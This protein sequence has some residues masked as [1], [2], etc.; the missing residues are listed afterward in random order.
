[1]RA[2]II[3]ISF[4]LL[5]T[6]CS[7]PTCREDILV[8]EEEVTV[9]VQRLE[10]V[11]FS[12]ES[13]QDVAKFLEDYPTFT[14]LFLDGDQY[15]EDSVLAEKVYG[16][17]NNAAVDTLYQEATVEYASFTS[18]Q[19]EMEMIFARLKSLYPSLHSPTVQTAVTG[20]YNDLYISDSLIIIGIDFFIGEE[21]TYRPKEIPGY[22]LQRYDREHLTAI[23][24]KFMA[25]S[26][27][28]TGSG[29][30]LLSEMIDFGK[31]YYLTSRLLPCTPDSILLGYTTEDM[32]LINENES[33][34][35]ANFVQNE[36]LYETSHIVKQKFLGERPNVHEIN[37][38]CPG[39]IGAWVGWQIVESYM[40][41]NNV[42]V[43]S[44][45]EDTDNEVIFRNSG[46]KPS[47]D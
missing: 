7:E 46:Y 16:L 18:I 8:P 4:L 38:D 41:R 17:I 42:S 43:R 29:N 30:T 12:S 36:I 44:L 25:G 33:I 37:Q 45:L 47:P 35:W 31:T 22:I 11:L 34:I 14:Q 24:A 10:E 3:V 39:R 23:I 19:G 2:V 26:L 20:L 9:N 40:E 21:A 15:P 6:S 27:V 32:E 13:I 5:I 28:N 1:M